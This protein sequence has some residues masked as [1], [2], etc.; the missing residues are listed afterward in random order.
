MLGVT[1]EKS[2]I[3]SCPAQLELKSKK[4]RRKNVITTIM[5]VEFVIRV[6]NFA[7]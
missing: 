7:Y 1:T 6:E 4:K 5:S 3:L 2:T